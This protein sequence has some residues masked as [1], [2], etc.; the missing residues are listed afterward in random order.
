[1]S[2]LSSVAETVI[3]LTCDR[4]RQKRSGKKKKSTKHDKEHENVNIEITKTLGLFLPS[5]RV[6]HMPK[7]YLKYCLAQ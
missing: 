5:L 4:T 1:M 2:F 7:Y 3:L 6:Q